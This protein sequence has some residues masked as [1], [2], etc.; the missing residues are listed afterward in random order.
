M[1]CHLQMPVHAELTGAQG[2]TAGFSI[3]ESE[4]STSVAVRAG[5]PCVS[6]QGE[7]R[8]GACPPSTSAARTGVTQ[9]ASGVQS[10]VAE[11]AVVCRLPVQSWC[12]ALV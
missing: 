3:V 12:P 4:L 7:P 10:L 8:S 9:G 1:P 2:V 5:L 6:K 11:R